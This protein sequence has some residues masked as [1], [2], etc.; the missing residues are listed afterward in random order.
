MKEIDKLAKYINMNETPMSWK[1]AYDYIRNKIPEKVEWLEKE[2]GLAILE[3]YQINDEKFRMQYFQTIDMINQDRHLKTI[4]YLWYYILFIDQTGLYKD[5]WRWKEN[6]QLYRYAGNEILPA[7]VM[8]GGWQLHQNM[9]KKK[10]YDEIQIEEQKRNIRQC[11]LKDRQQFHIEGIR[12]SQ[13]VWGAYFMRGLLIQVGRL[14]YE[15]PSQPPRILKEH[16]WDF[17][18]SHYV[19]IHIPAGTKLEEKE[20]S[21]SLIDIKKELKRINPDI[22]IEAVKY[23]TYTW[24]LCNELDDILTKESNILKFKNRFDIILQTENIRDF[25]H[26][27]F[28]ENRRVDYHEL[29]EDTILQKRLKEELLKRTKLHIGL[30]VL[31]EN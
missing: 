3:Y 30:G 21:K 4:C 22:E 28:Q 26:F 17:N 19:A 23:Y 27:V 24:L 20:V 29:R 8:L 7:V 5:V 6:E 9:M 31:K 14:Q 2:N 1:I 16:L 12:F 10:N 13:M 15:Y 25:L 11:C 18:N